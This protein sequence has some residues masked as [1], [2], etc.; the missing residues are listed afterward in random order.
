[1]AFAHL[2]VTLVE[3]VGY[4]GHNAQQHNHP[5]TNPRKLHD[6]SHGR[7]DHD[8]VGALRGIDERG[9]GIVLKRAFAA[10][11]ADAAGDAA[12]DG[13]F[14]ELEDFRGDVFRLERVG[15]LGERGKGA[16]FGVRAAVEQE[17]VHGSCSFRVVQGKEK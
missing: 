1:M 11:A 17:D 8:A 7:T 2:I 9:H 4:C 3:P 5:D 15:D 14:A 12:A 13:L 6:Y 10:F 16:A